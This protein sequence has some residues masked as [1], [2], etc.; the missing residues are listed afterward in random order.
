MSQT[1]SL[2]SNA[3]DGSLARG[4][5]PAGVAN[6]VVPGKKPAVHEL[7]LLVDVAKPMLLAPPL[8]KRPTWKAAT[9]VDPDDR[10][11]GSSSVA[12][13]LVEFV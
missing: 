3:T 7:P 6:T 12:C 2:A 4:Y 13:W 11:S 10:V 5:G 9:I 8:K 1:P